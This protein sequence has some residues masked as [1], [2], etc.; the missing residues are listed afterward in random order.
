MFFPLV[1]NWKLLV[2]SATGLG[3]CN[4]SEHGLAESV[5][6]W[7][8]LLHFGKSGDQYQ[9]SKASKEALWLEI[10]NTTDIM[11]LLKLKLAFVSDC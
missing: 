6:F 11:E 4:L 9:L 10:R 7:N 1:S 5:I 8:H 2:L 3:F